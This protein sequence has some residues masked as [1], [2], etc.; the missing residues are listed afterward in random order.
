MEYIIV[1]KYVKGFFVSWHYLRVQ[2]NYY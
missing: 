1:C 2:S